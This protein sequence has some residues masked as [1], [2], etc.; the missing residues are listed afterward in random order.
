MQVRVVAFA[1]IREILG[2]AVLQRD[3]REGATAGELWAGLA[4]EFPALAELERSTRFVRGGAF[5]DRLAVL[6]D[7]D[8]LALLPPYGGG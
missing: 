4:R 8:E 5:V 1:R 3:E 7:G 6:R 2:A